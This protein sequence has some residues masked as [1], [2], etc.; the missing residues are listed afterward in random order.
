MSRCLFIGGAYDGTWH[1]VPYDT[2]TWTLRYEAHDAS[3][4]SY[5]HFMLGIAEYKHVTYMERLWRTP[6]TDYR[7]FTHV[8]LDE[9]T[10]FQM[11]LNGYRR[12]KDAV[13]G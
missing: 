3:I 9:D 1:D 12:G 6:R 13:Q 5:A 7:L 11:L 8:A 10:A 2:Q 4:G